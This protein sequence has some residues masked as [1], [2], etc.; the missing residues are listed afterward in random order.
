[1]HN[2]SFVFENLRL[3]LSEFETL[4]DSWPPWGKWCFLH[5]GCVVF[6]ASCYKRNVIGTERA[7]VCV[8]H[9]L[10]RNHSQKTPMR[11]I[12]SSPPRA[13]LASL[14]CPSCS[15]LSSGPLQPELSPPWAHGACA[16]YTGLLVLA[17]NAVACLPAIKTFPLLLCVTSCSFLGQRG[18]FPS[19]APVTTEKFLKLLYRA[20]FTFCVMHRAKSLSDV[21]CDN[22][23]EERRRQLKHLEHFCL[24]V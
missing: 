14:T 6:L 1:M 22:T 9:A 7:C 18:A 24:L 20:L 19:I 10:F 13:C 16:D 5:P 8:L 21:S 2:C 15:P 3:G 23:N 11:F 17:Q 12:L 4:G